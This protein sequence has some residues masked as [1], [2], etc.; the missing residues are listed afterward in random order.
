MEAGK[1][2]SYTHIV[3]ENDTASALGSGGLDVYATPAM[4]CGMEHAAYRCAAEDNL[5][6][7]GTL[8]NVSHT[9]ACLAGSRVRFTAELISSEGRKFVFRVTAEDESGIIGEGIQERFVIDPD[10]FMGKLKK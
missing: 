4:I 8:V 6:T 5:E 2:Y 7:V 1:K 9:R 10:R 3:T